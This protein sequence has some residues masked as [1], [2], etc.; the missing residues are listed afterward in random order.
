[1]SFFFLILFLSGVF[2]ENREVFP[3]FKGETLSGSIVSLDDFPDARAIV[4]SFWASWCKPCI[5][6]LRKMEEFY[7][8]YSQSGL[9]VLAVNEDASRS[10]KK[11]ESIV[12]SNKFSFEIILDKN[13]T[14]KKSV[15]ISELPTTFLLDGKRNIVYHHIG[16]KPGDEK[17][18]F[19]KIIELLQAG[20]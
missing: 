16:Y 7:R 11:V 5:K 1:M 13:G 19:E 9:V 14:I 18:L 6:E 8:I 3:Q 20:K 2:G 12:R 4:V 15:G 17:E 10:K